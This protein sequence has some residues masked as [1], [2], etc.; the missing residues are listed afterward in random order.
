MVKGKLL[1]IPNEL[2]Y[3]ALRVYTPYIEGLPYSSLVDAV[4]VNPL[5]KVG[6]L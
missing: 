4:Y 5:N 2:V 1:S 3:K 6:E